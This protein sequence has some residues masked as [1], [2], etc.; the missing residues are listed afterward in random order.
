MNKISEVIIVEGRDDIRRLNEVVSADMIETHGMGLNDDIMAV[1]EQAYHKRGI[2]IFTDPDYAG[3]SIRK[4]ITAR[5][6]QAKHAFITRA[7][8]TPDKKGSLGVEHASDEAIIN[9]LSQ[10]A[11]PREEIQSINIQLLHRYGLL[12]GPHAKQRRK[13][14]GER[15]RIGYTNGK[16]LQKRLATFNITEEQFINTMN[17]IMEEEDER[18]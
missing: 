13:K 15:L 16:Q 4:Q 12:G 7:E 11:T 14:L 8:G 6:P 18:L 17:Q 2:I 1:I 3:E 5:C 9:A 10:V